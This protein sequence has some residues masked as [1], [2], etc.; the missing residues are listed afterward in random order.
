MQV[1]IGK[2]PPQSRSDYVRV[3]V[4]NFDSVIPAIK[5]VMIFFP[6]SLFNFFTIYTL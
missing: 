5:S 6:H 2:V 1:H 3:Y 4:F